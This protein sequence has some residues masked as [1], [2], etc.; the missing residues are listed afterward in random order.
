MVFGEDLGVNRE[1]CVQVSTA[2]G[3]GMAHL[4]LTCGAVTGAL[5]VLGLRHGGTG[6]Q[7]QAT[8][9]LATE[10]VK[11]FREAHGSINCTELIGYDLSDPEQ[12]AEASA[13]IVFASKC[14]D[15]VRTAARILEE[16][17]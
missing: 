3:G 9:G 7:K 8:Y 5:M 4:G 14:V 2:F 6:G 12:L 16:M 10:F 11:R 13:R 17:G 1:T 15:Y